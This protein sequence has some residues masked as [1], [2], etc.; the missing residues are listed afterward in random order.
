VRVTSDRQ[1][2]ILAGET[3]PRRGGDRLASPSVASDSDETAPSSGDGSQRVT[4]IS[5]RV[6]AVI[7]QGLYSPA[8][9]APVVYSA[10][11]AANDVST[12]D[13]V[14]TAGDLV[15]A[16]SGAQLPAVANSASALPTL[17]PKVHQAY[18]VSNRGSSSNGANAYLRT[19]YLSDRTPLIDTYA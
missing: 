17:P 19:Q 14:V 12:T 4:Y 15:A 6:D 1:T 3:A 10:N 7:T 9:K 5:A 13:D 16:A 11:V 2:L 8:Q 18:V